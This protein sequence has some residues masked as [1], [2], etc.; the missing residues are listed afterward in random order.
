MSADFLVLVFTSIV[1][2]V[3][4]ALVTNAVLPSGVTA[5]A[6]GPVP[7]AM[8]VGFLVQVPTS[9]VETE[10]LRPLVTRAIVRHRARAGTADTRPGTTPCSAPANPSTTTPRTHRNRRIAAPL[11]VPDHLWLGRPAQRRS[12]RD[13]GNRQNLT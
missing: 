5:T 10:P 7:T 6:N 8:S 1:D 12:H 13:S 9:M 4:L 2:T 11:A 3:S